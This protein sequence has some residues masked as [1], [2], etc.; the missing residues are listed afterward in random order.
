MGTHALARRR[1]RCLFEPLEARCLLAADLFGSAADAAAAFDAFLEIDGIR[2]ESSDKIHKETIEIQS[3]SWGA[4][5]TGAVRP[6]PVTADDFDFVA[7]VSSATPLLFQAAATGEHISKAVLYVRKA[8]GGQQDFL[9][10]TLE[11]VLVSSVQSRSVNESLPVEEVSL[12]FSAIQEVYWPTGDDGRVGDPVT[13][14]WTLT[15]NHSEPAPGPSLLDQQPP[16]ASDQIEAFLKINGI[17]GDS[18][19]AKHKDWIEIE[20]FSWGMSNAGSHAGGGGGGAGKVS[21]QDFHFVMP[22]NKSSPQLLASAAAGRVLPEATLLVRRTSPGQEADYL[23]IKLQ[24][25]LVSSIQT[26]S[27]D[28]S[29]PMEEVTLNFTKLSQTYVAQDPATGKRLGTATGEWDNRQFPALYS[30]GDSVLDE[31]EASPGTV[32]MF[33]A[34]NGVQ[35]DAADAKHKDTIEIESFS[36]GLSRAISERGGTGGGAGKVN[37][38][39]FHFVTSV[40]ET[41]PELMLACATGEHIAKAVLFVRKSGEESS[42]DY[43]KYKLSDVLVSSYQIQSVDESQPLEEFTL[44]FRGL[45]ESY[46]PTAPR[47]RVLPAVQTSWAVPLS[48]TR[49]PGDSALDDTTAPAGAADIFLG[50]EGIP[51][52]SADKDHKG[53][54]EILSFS[55]GVH[56]AGAFANGGGGGAGRLALEPFHF[57]TPVSQASPSLLSAVL[58]G[59]QLPEATLHVRNAGS[60]GQDYYT[61]KLSDVLISSYQTQ[62][63]DQAVPLDEATLNFARLD[64]AFQ[65]PDD[66]GAPASPVDAGFDVDA[67]QDV[68]VPGDDLLAI[69]SPPVETAAAFIKFDGVDGEGLAQGKVELQSFSW[70]V[71]NHGS[72]GSG[73]GGGA[74]KVSM[75]DFHFVTM[76]TSASPELVLA[77]ATGKHF[78]KVHFEVLR[79]GGDARP[80]Y[81]KYE[82]ENT[83]VSSYQISAS[84]D[85]MPLEEF[86]L[87]FTRLELPDP[88]GQ[89]VLAEWSNETQP[90]EF[91]PGDSILDDTT[92]PPIDGQMLLAVEGIQGESADQDHKGWIEVESFS[93]GLSQSA[94]S[95]GSGGSAGKVSMQDFHFV[96]DLSQ[97]SP[98]LFSAVAKG[99]HFP[100]AVLTLRQNGAEPRNYL[101]YELENVMISSYQAH[102]H[103]GAVPTDQFSLNFEEVKVNYQAPTPPGAANADAFFATLSASS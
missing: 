70:G 59:Q 58:S 5:Q 50:I 29:V 98:Q 8:G 26:Q 42:L 75:Q 101:K 61:I 33:L 40:N 69:T 47:G 100:T 43:L 15:P 93:W 4:T 3:F 95:P 27:H 22:A 82:M 63:V 102:G 62:S 55:W 67:S 28:S 64:A 38:Q 103:G 60:G 66:S 31:T 24:D 90:A 17:L 56:N 11:D 1:R 74:G 96:A 34:V 54:I 85:A 18:A 65:P 72:F 78:D 91:L 12:S 41:S 57:V 71:S 36:W 84:S 79:A 99:K 13:A 51:G 30:L 68:F 97:A 81:M 46:V 19:D 53:E 89:S 73:G 21:M 10:V 35:G 48:A 7:P 32:D 77:C 2:G 14:E 16:G 37:V 76:P 25:I 80:I 52:E 6:D 23:K 92:A 87:N 94:G 9:K 49:S 83:M 88:E 45:Q 44:S 20:S 39:D 86:T